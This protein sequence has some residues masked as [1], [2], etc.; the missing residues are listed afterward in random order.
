MAKD[1]PIGMVDDASSSQVSEG[2]RTGEVE[3][4]RLGAT[5]GTGQDAGEVALDAPYARG[6][7]IKAKKE[8][9]KESQEKILEVQ[10]D[11]FAKGSKQKVK[12]FS[13]ELKKIYAK[14]LKYYDKIAAS[15]TKGDLAT[16]IKQY[17]KDFPELDKK[18]VDIKKDINPLIKKWKKK[19]LMSSSVSPKQKERIRRKIKM[20][21]VFQER[22]K[23][24][25]QA[26]SSA[27]STKFKSTRKP[28]SL[29]KKRQT[30]GLSALFNKKAA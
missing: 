5:E 21:E 9:V 27:R 24:A 30:S 23:T 15:K 7:A 20:L 6:R 25:K 13:K 4:N 14:E 16:W 8:V 2:N 29:P 19:D 10:K 26:R 3:I 22:R 11:I 1:K 18:Y 28:S 12:D 17:K